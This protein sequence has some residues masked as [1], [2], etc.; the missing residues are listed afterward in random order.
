MGI[1]PTK[2]I[3]P[4]IRHEPPPRGLPFLLKGVLAKNGGQYTH[5]KPGLVQVVYGNV[6]EGF[7]DP[8]GAFER[9]N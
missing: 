4:T 2:N 9:R 6:A 5:G 3:N 7:C 8:V 1:Y